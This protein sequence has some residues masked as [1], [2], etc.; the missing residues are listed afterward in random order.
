MAAHLLLVTYAAFKPSPRVM[1]CR[2][3]AA[4]QGCCCR[5]QLLLLRLCCCWVCSLLPPGG[6]HELGWAWREWARPA[7]HHAACSARVIIINSKQWLQAPAG[8][9]PWLGWAWR[10]W[11]RPAAGHDA[12]SARVRVFSS[13]SKQWLQAPAGGLHGLRWAG[14]EW[15]WTAAGHA[16]SSSCVTAEEVGS[17]PYCT[18]SALMQEAGTS[19]DSLL[20]L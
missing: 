3:R 17:G 7:G 20:L 4:C 9:P 1:P 19:S 8:G 11:A 16:A 13:N 2:C 18:L 10:E 14:H 5:P 15:V 6:L 12:C